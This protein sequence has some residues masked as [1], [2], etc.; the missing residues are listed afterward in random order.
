[1][2]KYEPKT[3]DDKLIASLKKKYSKEK[4]PVTKVEH[5]SMNEILKDITQVPAKLHMTGEPGK[6]SVKPTKKD[7]NPLH[8]GKG[9]DMFK[10]TM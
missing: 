7:E 8:T 4:E 3:M 6:I 1:M 5:A 2:E 10:S 9:K